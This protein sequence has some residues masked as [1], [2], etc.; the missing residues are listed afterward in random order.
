M[1]FLSCKMELEC[2]DTNCTGRHC[3]NKAV[4]VR[5]KEAKFEKYV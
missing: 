5:R 3:L 4:E 2:K 1:R